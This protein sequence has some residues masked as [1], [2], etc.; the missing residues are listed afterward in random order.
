M[1]F[2]LQRMFLYNEAILGPVIDIR[3]FV[4]VLELCICFYD[5]VL[6]VLVEEKS[7]RNPR[8]LVYFLC[9]LSLYKL[10]TCL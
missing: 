1:C 8:T 6:F 2:L 5:L 10:F 3:L 7:E 9:L 4:S